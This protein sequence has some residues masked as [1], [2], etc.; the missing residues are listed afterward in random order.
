MTNIQMEAIKWWLKKDWYYLTFSYNGGVTI[1][2]DDNKHGA[3]FADLDTFNSWISK[4]TERYAEER[5]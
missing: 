5:E 4:V 2:T 3:D 1:R